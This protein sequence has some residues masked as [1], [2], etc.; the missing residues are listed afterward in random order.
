[1]TIVLVVLLAGCTA[2]GRT[3]VREVAA[4]SRNGCPAAYPE[5][6][7]ISAS[8]TAATPPLGGLLACT[9]N[10][11]QGP[12]L[13]HDGGWAAWQVLPGVHPS[14]VVGGGRWSHWLR[15]RV[16]VPAGVVMPGQSA[17]V[18]APAR[19]ISFRLDRDWS[20]AWA[21]LMA[22][23]QALPAT[24]HDSRATAARLGSVRGRALVTCALTALHLRR[25]PTLV[26]AAP[27]APSTVA[28][29][30]YGATP[31]TPT[32]PPAGAAGGRAPA[33]RGLTGLDALQATWDPSTS[34]CSQDW[35]RSD[36]LL[37]AGRG[38]PERW[39][40]AWQR[41]DDWLA[42]VAG[43]LQWLDQDGAVTLRVRP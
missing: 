22:G 5:R 33:L 6:L 30:P 29:T 16:A 17:L 32:S 28:S 43:D 26:G 9:R 35:Q 19:A 2:G 18:W 42:R 11:G 39:W 14:R 15:T 8:A 3:T 23:V 4:T 40:S 21:S 1:V 10:P 12:V 36:H 34:A 41:A 25:T 20:V 13:L 7:T 37:E 38:S 24:G 27:A 31:T